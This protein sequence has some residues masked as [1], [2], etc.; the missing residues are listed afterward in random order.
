MSNISTLAGTAGAIFS[1]V[2]SR[3]EVRG[4][5][6]LSHNAAKQAGAIHLQGVSTLIVQDAARLEHNVA[7]QDGG[8]VFAELSS[9][10]HILTL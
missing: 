4:T 6:Q 9:R 3:V 5:T 1:G 7:Q 8:A 10:C 2:R